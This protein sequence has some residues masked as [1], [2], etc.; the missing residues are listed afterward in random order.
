MIDLISIVFDEELPYLQTQARTIDRYI[1]PDD[2]NAIV[3]VVNDVDSVAD[4]IDTAW[5]GQ[6]QEKVEIKCY[7][8][9]NYTSRINGWENQQLCKLLAA[10]ESTA[11]WSMILD[12]KTWFVQQFNSVEF[13]DEQH[14]PKTGLIDIFPQFESSH[15]F[16][17]EYFD[18]T[19][20]K[21]IGPGGVP[22]M[23]HTDTIKSLVDS[24]DTFIEFFQINVR[25]PNLITE[26]YLYSAYV[27]K[28]HG[29]LDA[30][31]NKTQYYN[32]VNIA[33]FEAAEFNSI[34]NR[35]KNDSK[36][37]TA[38]MHRRTYPL[39]S[40]QQIAQWYNFLSSK[41]ITPTHNCL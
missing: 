38:S 26:F 31:Y 9:W 4:R 5:W 8:R 25:Y 40:K 32:V 27:I 7:S 36:L 1:T 16:V 11:T 39:L 17:Q 34:L 28:L 33:D 6:H 37:L 41:N 2:V 22:F 12:A 35:V 14:R 15:K 24:I 13:F 29:S 10:S 30:L 21:S 3:V 23:M 18:I 20:P 19:M